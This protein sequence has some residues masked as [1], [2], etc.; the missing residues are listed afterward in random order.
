MSDNNNGFSVIVSFDFERPRF[1]I[2]LDNIVFE[3][4][5]DQSFGIEDGVHGVFGDL[6]FGGVS[7]HSF[8]I[9]EGNIRGGGSVS[10]VVSDDFNSI[11]LPNSNTRVGG[12]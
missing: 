10:L 7:D 11:V 4:S 6:I 2:F 9:G 3:F 5:S 1:H 8:F 12:S